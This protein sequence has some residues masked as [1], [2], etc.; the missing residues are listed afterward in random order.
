MQLAHAITAKKQSNPLTQVAQ[1]L[2]DDVLVNI[3]FRRLSLLLEV[4]QV[5]DFSRFLKLVDRC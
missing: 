2:G 4:F 1:L 3:V 5:R